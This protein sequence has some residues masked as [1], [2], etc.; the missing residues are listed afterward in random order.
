MKTVTEKNV[1]LQRA[2]EVLKEGGYCLSPSK[3]NLT[4]KEGK[5]FANNG[6]SI[7]PHAVNERTIKDQYTVQYEV[8]PS[9]ENC[10]FEGGRNGSCP[11]ENPCDEWHFIKCNDEGVT[12]QDEEPE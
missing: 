11:V 1:S 7:A 10:F 2:W 4:I 9:C 12:I 5:M 6:M 8:E 3:L